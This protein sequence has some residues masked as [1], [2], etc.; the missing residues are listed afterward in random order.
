[1]N[2]HLAEGILQALL[3]AELPPPERA[4]AEAHLAACPACAGELRALRAAGERTSALLAQADVAAPVAQAQMSFRRRRMAARQHRF[5][6]ARRALLRA[7]VLVL[8]LAGVAAAAVPGSP[9]RAWIEDAVLP[10]ERSPQAQEIQPAPAPAAAPAPDLGA[11]SGVTV[12]V[13]DGRVRVALTGAADLRLVV[14]ST[15]EPGARVLYRGPEHRARFHTSPGRIEL[16][17]ARG[18]EV[19]VELPQAAEAAAVEVNGQVYVA[20]DGDELR[21][22]VPQAGPESTD[23]LVFRVGS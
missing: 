7:A 6:E 2:K 4:E 16:A 10:R 15:P 20:K 3:D 5:V 22:L 9:V 1:M 8:G 12:P 21:P 13:R 18:G 19:T 14:Q 23:E 11:P 17:G